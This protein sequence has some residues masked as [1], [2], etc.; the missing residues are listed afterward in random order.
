MPSKSHQ[1]TT[2]SSGVGAASRK[3]AAMQIWVTQADHSIRSTYLAKIGAP[4]RTHQLWQE[5]HCTCETA[6]SMPRPHRRPPPPPLGRLAKGGAAST[7]ANGVVGGR[8]GWGGVQGW[9]WGGV[10]RGDGGGQGGK[11]VAPRA[12]LP[13]LPGDWQEGAGCSTPAGPRQAWPLDWLSDC[14]LVPQ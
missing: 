6:C 8:D 1:N 3:T 13:P 5:F 10:R 12:H 7:L 11:A 4:L 9:R 2:V 14:A